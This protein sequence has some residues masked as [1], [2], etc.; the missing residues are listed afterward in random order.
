MALLAAQKGAAMVRVHDVTETVQALNM[1][2]HC[3]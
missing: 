3:E 1:L 2:H